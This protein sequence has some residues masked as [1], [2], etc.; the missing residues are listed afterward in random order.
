MNMVIEQEIEIE[1]PVEVVWQTLTEPELVRQWF[2]AD[3]EVEPVAGAAGTVTFREEARGRR[4]E[5]FN[6]T[7]V[8]VEPERRFTYRWQY[9]DGVEAR[10][11]NS[12]LV[13]FTL[14]ALDG[15]GTRLLVVETGVE[16]MEGWDTERQ[17]AFA[18]DHLG[19]W[20]VLLGRLRDRVEG[21]G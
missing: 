13:E 6:V 15:G 5:T 20:A 16:L 8:S 19:G 10:E 11:G 2:A 21:R 7:V 4:P 17:Q 1:A 9:P 14:T 3:V 18:A 12:T